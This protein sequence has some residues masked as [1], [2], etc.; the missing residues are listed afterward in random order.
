MIPTTPVYQEIVDFLAAGMTPRQLIAF[1]PSTE[2]QQRVAEL[3]QQEKV[4]GLSDIEAAEL[5]HFMHL[6]HL[7]R[8]AKA[9]A[10]KFLQP[11]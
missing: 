4:E 5:N 1:H 8:L 10:R 6:E 9:R 2:A 7:L 11:S 3:L